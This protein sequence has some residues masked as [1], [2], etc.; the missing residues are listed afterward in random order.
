MRTLFY[1]SS[2]I[3]LSLLLF[4]AC[5]KEN[6]QE[7][8]TDVAATN[9]NNLAKIDDGSCEY[10]DSSFTIW[11]NGKAGYWGN[12]E[13]GSFSVTSCF[14]GIETIFLNPDTTINPPDTTIDNSVT[15]PDTT[16]TPADTLINGDTYLLINSDVSG[17]YELV[18]KLLNKKNATDFKNGYLIFDAKL[19]A[20]A[21]INDFGVFIHGNH[22]NLGGDNCDQFHQSDP[23]SVSTQ[24]LDTSSFT[25]IVI[26]LIDFT[27]RHMQE[28]NVVFG[29][30]G[31]NATPNSN[32]ILINNV[33]WV[34]KLEE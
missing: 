25:E 7:G 13:T 27:N 8:C 20:D 11:S 21:T 29:I 34:S 23:V 16:I 32:L 18:I 1:T 33:K 30:S 31:S 9:Y 3:A 6:E 22:L 26:P 4:T 19:H 12:I 24:A 28:I 17:D 15:P 2:F 14:T 10:V 5:S